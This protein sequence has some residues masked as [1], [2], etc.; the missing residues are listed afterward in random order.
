MRAGTKRADDPRLSNQ[1]LSLGEKL[2]KPGEGVAA[3]RS[4]GA[5]HGRQRRLSWSGVDKR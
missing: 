2:A 1:A 5:V 3:Y 4:E